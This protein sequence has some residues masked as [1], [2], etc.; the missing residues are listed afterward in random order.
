M[1]I[2]AYIQ[3]GIIER[4]A[5]GL[6]DEQESGT[7][8]ALAKTHPEIRKELDE[9]QTS[10]EAYALAHALSPTPR[11]KADLMNKI[12]ETGIR[13][14]NAA[15]GNGKLIAFPTAAVAQ[16]R[17]QS[18]WKY[19]AAACIALLAVSSLMNYVF[20]SRWKNSENELTRIDAEKNTVAAQLQVQKTNYQLAMNDLHLLREPVIAKMELKNMMPAVNGQAV[21]F[22]DTRTNELFLDIRQLPAPPDSMQYQFWAIVQGKPVDAGM[23]T[24]CPANDTC[25]IHRMNTVLDASAF[26]ISLEKKGGNSQ[27]K[28]RIYMAYGI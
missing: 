10:L 28:G 20:Y 26:A 2:Q 24:L 21:V 18:Y 9:I 14:G 25:Y 27:P 19:A 23:I 11:L 13:A 7:L 12:Q 5:L 22:K 15:S 4:Y 3:S 6:A 8:E 16:S 1:D 17:G